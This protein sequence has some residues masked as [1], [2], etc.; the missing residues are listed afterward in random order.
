MILLSYNA[1]NAA[2]RGPC[3]ERLACRPLC[4]QSVVGWAYAASLDTVGLLTQLLSWPRRPAFAAH[5]SLPTTPTWTQFSPTSTNP[6]FPATMFL[7]HRHQ[8]FDNKICHGQWTGSR[9]LSLLR[10]VPA[11]AMKL[12]GRISNSFKNLHPRVL[13][14][15]ASRTQWPAERVSLR[16]S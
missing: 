6:C 4:L 12:S 16:P 14:G 10:F 1:W 7:P 13:L 5:C 9:P 3:R 15:S 2:A 11:P 8:P